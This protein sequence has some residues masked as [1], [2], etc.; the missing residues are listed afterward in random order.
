[1][2][3]IFGVLASVTFLS[4]AFYERVDAAIPQD[5]VCPRALVLYYTPSCPHSQRVIAYLNNKN[6][7]ISMKD[8]SVDAQAKEELRTQ[9][10]QMMVPCLFID[11]KP[12]YDDE[13]ILKWFQ[14]NTKC[15]DLSVRMALNSSH[16]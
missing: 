16:A 10:G 11:G 6:I 8:V 2:K 14:D 13:Q 4:L 15:F 12:L 9:G 1:M 7:K 3:R 5:K